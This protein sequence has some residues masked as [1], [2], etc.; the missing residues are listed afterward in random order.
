LNEEQKEVDIIETVEGFIKKFHKREYI[1]KEAA[2][3]ITCYKDGIKDNLGNFLSTSITNYLVGKSDSRRG[4]MARN[5]IIWI[6]QA[7]AANIIVEGKSLVGKIEQLEVTIKQLKDELKIQN[8]VSEELR[9]KNE[10]IQ[11]FI[12]DNFGGTGVVES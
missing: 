12:N 4:N 10:K 8:E 1:L 9:L 5:C 11:K 3:D 2:F 7:F 6:N